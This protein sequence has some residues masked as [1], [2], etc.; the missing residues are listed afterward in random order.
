MLLS[1]HFSLQWA[2]HLVVLLYPYRYKAK[3]V[4]TVFYSIMPATRAARAAAAAAT[5][6]PGAPA[7]AGHMA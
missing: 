5:A 4:T 6:T 2:N 1:R 3:Y 7:D